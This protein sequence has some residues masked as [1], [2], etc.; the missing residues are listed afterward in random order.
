M[1]RAR[2]REASDSR[3]LQRHP[4]QRDYGS[5]RDAAGNRQPGAARNRGARRAGRRGALLR[6]RG[7]VDRFQQGPVDSARRRA[8]YARGRGRRFADRRHPADS[9][10]MDEVL[11]V[12]QRPGEGGTG[13]GDGGAGNRRQ[14]SKPRDG[15]GTIIWPR[16]RRIRRRSK[17]CRKPR[18]TR[19]SSCTSTCSHSSACRLARCG[20]SKRSQKIAPMMGAT[21]F[22]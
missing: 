14:R 11:P 12:C 2:A 21:T 7:Q 15:C 17:R 22:S 20:T 9:H 5:R 4:R 6:S 3:R 16:S 1:G 8:G 13:E 19:W 10:R 18:A